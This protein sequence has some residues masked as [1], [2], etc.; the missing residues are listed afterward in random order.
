M[1]LAGSGRL[2]RMEGASYQAFASIARIQSHL[3]LNGPFLCFSHVF[4]LKVS[5]TSMYH[6]TLYYAPPILKDSRELVPVA[7][8]HFV[9]SLKFVEN[10]RW[11]LF[12]AQCSFAALLW[13]I[14]R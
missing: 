1:P 6:H 10:L 4:W 13:N 9:C 5:P 3:I 12:L 7:L 8:F 11:Q 14:Q 2:Q